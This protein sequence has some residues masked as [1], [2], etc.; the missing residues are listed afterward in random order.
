LLDISDFF[1]A[2]RGAEDPIVFGGETKRDISPESAARTGHRCR[3]CPHTC[4]DTLLPSST[5]V[6]VLMECPLKHRITLVL[7]PTPLARRDL[8]LSCCARRLVASRVTALFAIMP[9]GSRC[10]VLA[11]IAIELMTGTPLFS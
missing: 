10:I 8:N 6:L 2:H 5:A 11:N 1:L 4:H 7:P 9:C 3:A